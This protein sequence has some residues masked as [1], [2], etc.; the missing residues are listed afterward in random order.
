MRS[1]LDPLLETQDHKLGTSLL[2]SCGARHNSGYQ[3]AGKY[4]PTGHGGWWGAQRSGT[5]YSLSPVS[6]ED[7]RTFLLSHT[8]NCTS[9]KGTE[10]GRQVKAGALWHTKAGKTKQFI[11][12][13]QSCWDLGVKAHVQFSYKVRPLVAG[14]SMGEFPICPASPVIWIVAGELEIKSVTSQRALEKS[15][16]ALPP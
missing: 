1:V 10:Q 5:E 9:T 3:T 12:L 6:V 15:P 2:V 14:Y 13:S 7:C 16:L 8:F 11:R 4:I